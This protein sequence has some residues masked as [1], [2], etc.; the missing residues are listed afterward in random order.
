MQ[1]SG[2]MS[3]KFKNTLKN[4]EEA[5]NKVKKNIE[6]LNKL[7]GFIENKVGTID[8]N[9]INQ[10]KNCIENFNSD[11]IVQVLSNLYSLQGELLEASGA[12]WLQEK[13]PT[14]FKV[15][16]TGAVENRGG[17]LITDL[18]VIDFSQLNNLDDN[19]GISYTINKKTYRK[20]LKEF[21]LYLDCYLQ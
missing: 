15:Y 8:G 18:M 12:N 3:K 21:L 7:I 4:N 16:Q 5:L 1:T 6:I 19:I 10:L 20:S 2:F 9:Y 13:I 14:N 11:N 17:Q